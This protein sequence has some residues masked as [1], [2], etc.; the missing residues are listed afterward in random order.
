MLQATECGGPE[1]GKSSQVSGPR[2]L[3]L[4]ALCFPY[5][6]VPSLALWDISFPT[7]LS[8]SRH[9]SLGLKL[10]RIASQTYVQEQTLPVPGGFNSRRLGV[11]CAPALWPTCTGSRTSSSAAAVGAVRGPGG[12]E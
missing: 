8:T 3:G 10:D 2:G 4:G 12:A 7:K 6:P 9:T 5:K 1:I 11:R